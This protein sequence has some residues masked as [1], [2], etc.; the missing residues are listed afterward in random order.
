M[1]RSELQ[2]LV[3]EATRKG[4]RVKYGYCCYQED[5]KSTW[6]LFKIGSNYG[7][8]GWNWSVYYCKENDTIYVSGYRNM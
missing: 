1:T 6:D 3:D 7:Q 8:Y 2:A 4:S 5:K